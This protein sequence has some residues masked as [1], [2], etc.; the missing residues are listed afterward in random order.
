MAVG[1]FEV[2]LLDLER[3]FNVFGMHMKFVKRFWMKLAKCFI[4]ARVVLSASR[5]KLRLG[6]GVLFRKITSFSQRDRPIGLDWQFYN[7]TQPL[8][9]KLSS[10]ALQRAWVGFML[11]SLNY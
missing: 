3:F 6:L 2:D 5:P 7:L 1:V 10:L 4:F 11:L 8:S 9:V